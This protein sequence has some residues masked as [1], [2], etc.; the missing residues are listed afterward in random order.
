ME[1][2]KPLLESI[3]YVSVALII[4]FVIA[5]MLITFVRKLST[6]EK[7]RAWIKQGI[8]DAD[9]KLNSK[10]LIGSLMMVIGAGFFWLLFDI[11]L[12]SLIFDADKTAIM[13][14]VFMMGGSLMGVGKFVKK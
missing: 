10:D 3:Y 11:I 12:G 4:N 2:T 13:S 14:A 6:S 5:Y 9:E 7:F 8:E 1:L